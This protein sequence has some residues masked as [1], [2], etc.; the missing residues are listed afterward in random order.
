MLESPSPTEP[1]AI[2]VSILVADDDS[3]SRR[4]LQ[5]ALTRWGYSVTVACDGS[6]AW[7]HL[8]STDR[9]LLAIL[10]WMMPG[11]DG[12]A[13]CK[14]L[15]VAYRTNPAYVILLTA[16]NSKEHVVQGL[17]SGANDYLVKPC[18]LDELRARV[19]VGIKMVSLQ[20]ELAER[21]RELENAILTIRRLEGLLPTCMY[22][23]R[24]RDENSRWHQIESYISKRSHARFSHSICPDCYQNEVKPQLN[25][26]AT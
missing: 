24:I 18:D 11:L 9:P 21:V 1:V 8:Q 22:C 6:E 16:R 4:L 14:Q 2:S 20:T 25:I 26:T 5:A 17:E 3:V 12:I 10:D 19:E 13:V 7:N 23:K 15:R